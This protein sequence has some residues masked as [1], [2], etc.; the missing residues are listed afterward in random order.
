MANQATYL[1]FLR[2]Q[3]GIPVA[4]LP[5][6]DPGIPYSLGFGNGWIGD[7]LTSVN[8]QTFIADDCVHCMSASF[9][10]EIQADQPGQVFFENY[11]LQNGIAKGQ[12]YS[13][14]AGVIESAK[15]ESTESG[16]KIGEGLSNLSLFDLQRLK[17]P[18][19]R[20]ALSYLQSLGN[21]WLLV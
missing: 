15:D 11:R 1:A 2:Q 4:A 12:V 13:F 16:L 17:D 6:T 14:Y 10:L 18:F 5:D 21:Q 20:R 7:T 19:G 3:V 8:A 9:L